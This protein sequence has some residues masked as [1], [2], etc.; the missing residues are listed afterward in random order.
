MHG[1]AVEPWPMNRDSCPSMPILGIQDAQAHPYS[2]G[3][4]NASIDDHALGVSFFPWISF[5][6]A[7]LTL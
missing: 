5:L 2:D 3:D 4:N 7:C 1:K 6:T